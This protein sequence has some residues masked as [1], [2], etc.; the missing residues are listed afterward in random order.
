M[1]NLYNLWNLKKKWYFS[2]N[3]RKMIENCL[4]LVLKTLII[5]ITQYIFFHSKIIHL[6]KW[7]MGKIIDIILV[8][9]ACI[10]YI[11]MYVWFLMIIWVILGGFY[12]WTFF[13]LSL[14][15]WVTGQIICKKNN[16]RDFDPICIFLTIDFCENL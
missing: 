15:F 6:E 11:C 3:M 13:D 14:C 7:L 16:F 2:F 12:S 8:K 9:Y 4:E 5:K 10:I 1:K